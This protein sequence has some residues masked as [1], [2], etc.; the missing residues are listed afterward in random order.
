MSKTLTPRHS[1]SI[2]CVETRQHDKAVS[3]VMHTLRVCN[4]LFLKHIYWFSNCDFPLRRELEQE[5]G[6]E[7][8]TWI[9]ISDFNDQLSFNE[10]L[11]DLTLGLIARVVD[12]DANLIVQSDGYAVNANAWTDAFFEY[13]YIGA[14]W[15][16]EDEGRNVGNGGFSFRSKKL[17]RALLDLRKRY[18][19]AELLANTTDILSEDKFVGFSIPE[20]NL[21][22]KVYRP[23]LE[24][25]YGIRF[26]PSYLADQF[27]IETNSHSEWFGK[28]F[29]FHGHLT[30]S[31]YAKPHHRDER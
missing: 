23:M 29:G 22:S 6:T 24:K 15:P 25:E 2:S 21:I 31:F 8:L 14:R 13:D 19:L 11:S 1:L 9:V 30:G 27:S 28:S 12:T 18:K 7:F 5:F 16:W 4:N 10:Q 20:D 26:A 17:Y 3:A